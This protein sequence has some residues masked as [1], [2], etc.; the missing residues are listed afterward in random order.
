MSGQVR[1]GVVEAGV[2]DGRPTPAEP[3]FPAAQAASACTASMFHWIGNTEKRN[4]PAGS[5]G[6]CTVLERWRVVFCVP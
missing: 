1:M 5:F 2:E 4:A 3:S 6:L